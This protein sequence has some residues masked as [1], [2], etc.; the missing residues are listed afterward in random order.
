MGNSY[1]QEPETDGNP[2]DSTGSDTHSGNTGGTIPNDAGS[3]DPEYDPGASEPADD[4]AAVLAE[5]GLG[6]EK[7]GNR[8]EV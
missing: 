3:Y 4:I 2:D 8:G 7:S 5:K 1:D 6:I